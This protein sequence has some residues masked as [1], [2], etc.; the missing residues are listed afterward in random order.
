MTL[1]VGVPAD[2]K[3]I[4]VVPRVNLVEVPINP[5]PPAFTPDM[6]VLDP[7]VIPTVR[8]K[9]EAIAIEHNKYF[10]FI[11]EDWNPDQLIEALIRYY[12]DPT[13]IRLDYVRH[14]E[15]QLYDQDDRNPNGRPYRI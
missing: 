14:A 10:V 6:A 9:K 11:P 7:E 15:G 5:I 1:F 3:R 4:D 13:P 12:P 2:G 8:Y